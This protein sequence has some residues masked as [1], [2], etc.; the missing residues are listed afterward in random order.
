VVSVAPR[1]L[2]QILRMFR[3]ALVPVYQLGVTGGDT[4]T[5]PGERPI[6]LSG[7]RDRFEGWLPAYMAAGATEA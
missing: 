3:T 4:L 6:L 5:L 2:D 1:N 7:L